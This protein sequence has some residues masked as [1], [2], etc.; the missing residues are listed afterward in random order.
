MDEVSNR[1]QLLNYVT[2][3]LQATPDRR[4]T[5]YEPR[6]DDVIIAGYMKTGTTWLQQILHQI[7]TGGDESLSDIYDVTWYLPDYFHKLDLDLSRDQP[8]NAG[9][10]FKCHAKYENIPKVDGKTR[11]V[12][13]VRDPYDAEWS[14]IKFLW[15]Y[16]GADRD[17]SAEEYHM[18]VESMKF[19]GP[20]EDYAG[21]FLSWWPHR[22][23]PN[24]LWV[25]YED[26]HKN[27][28]ASIDRIAQFYIGKPLDAKT[29]DRVA[30]FCTFEYMSANKHKFT[31]DQ[32]LQLMAQAAKLDDQQK[33]KSLCGLVRTDGGRVGQGSQALYEETKRTI[34]ERWKETVG[35]EFGVE[36]YKAM[37]KKCTW[38]G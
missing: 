7:R 1:M 3:D 35:K 28:P 14:M 23:D 20:N 37:L 16:F 38:F 11:F 10:I 25:H 2:L 17:M 4:A 13:I 18:F 19:R 26:L 30:S 24:V 33:I 32:Q 9:R 12:V 8:G 27:L 36:S 6:P 22:Q 34:D 29:R 31:A 5:P 15:R 21:W